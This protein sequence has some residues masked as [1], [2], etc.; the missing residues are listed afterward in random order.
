M[1]LEEI[2]AVPTHYLNHPPG[3]VAPGERREDMQNVKLHHTALSKGYV[4]VHSDGI[5]EDY[6]GRYGKGYTIKTHNP[7]STR[8]CYISY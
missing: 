4:S 8:Y 5:K 1:G 3:G 7:N 2:K 6:C